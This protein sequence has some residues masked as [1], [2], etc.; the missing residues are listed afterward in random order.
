MWY[1]ACW[2]C[3]AARGSKR[4]PA[5]WARLLMHVP[6][7]WVVISTLRARALLNNQ[8]SIWNHFALRCYCL[9]IFFVIRYGFGRNSGK[10]FL[11][12]R[13]FP[14]GFIISFFY[15][16]SQIASIWYSLQI[17]WLKSERKSF[18][19]QR[20][21]LSDLREEIFQISERKSFKTVWF[22]GFLLKI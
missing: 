19:S 15:R 4:G 10:L 16:S 7:I 11:P 21:N 5:S 14:Q 2:C 6:N 17:T 12:Y 13:A 1:F 9:L 22:S 18:R 3:K 20:G 8:T